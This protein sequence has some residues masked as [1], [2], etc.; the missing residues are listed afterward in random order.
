[1][2][3]VWGYL[4]FAGGPRIFLGIGFWLDRGR[5][6]CSA[7]PPRYERFPCRE[8]LVGWRGEADDDFGCLDHKGL[9]N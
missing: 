9:S 7:N 3:T 6:H 4:P 8:T 1:M 5:I 2:T